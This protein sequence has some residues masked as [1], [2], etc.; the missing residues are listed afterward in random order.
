MIIYSTVF[1]YPLDNFNILGH[2]N[3]KEKIKECLQVMRDKP[4]LNRNLNS[5]NLYLFIISL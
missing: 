1:F 5:V 4:P 2:E 3:I